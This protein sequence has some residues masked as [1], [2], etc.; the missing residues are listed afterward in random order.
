MVLLLVSAAV[1]FYALGQIWFCQVVIYPLFARVGS[2]EYVEYHRFYGRRI[3]APVIL[4][5]FAS[6]LLPIA[7]W[8][9]PPSTAPPWVTGL[10]AMC[11]AVGLLLTVTV[12]IPRHARLETDGKHE[13]VIE[14]L[15]RYN[16]PR[17]LS[18]TGSTV[19]TTIMLLGAAS[20][21]TTESVA[22]RALEPGGMSEA[23]IV[24]DATRTHAAARCPDRSQARL[25]FGLGGR[26][27]PISEA[28][29]NMFLSDTITPRFPDG[30][31]VLE[32]KGQWRGADHIVSREDARVVEIMHEPSPA[33]DA[34]IDAIAEAYK[35][36]Y[37]Q[38]AV[39]VVHGHAPVCLH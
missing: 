27:G 5:G 13:R 36:Q 9:M 11:G 38:E 19:L 28:G 34:A 33:A 1:L 32:A 22:S 39:M 24:A 8:W 14:E 6:F 20:A 21:P 31:T 3:L 12:L 15:V 2:A 16:W 29:W 35:A 37:G 26:T 30:L 7:L 10:N 4:P 23:V 18:I 17:T 25:Y